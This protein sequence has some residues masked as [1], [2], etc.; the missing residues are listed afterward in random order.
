MHSC[1]ISHNRC[2]GPRGS[3]PSAPRGGARK[4]VGRACGGRR[5]VQRRPHPGIDSGDGGMTERGAS[6]RKLRGLPGAH[7]GSLAPCVPPK[8]ALGSIPA[9]GNA[10]RR[11]SRG[12]AP[13]DR[14]HVVKGKLLF[15][16]TGRCGG[17]SPGGA[18]LP[19]QGADASLMRQR[20]PK[21][22]PF[23]CCAS[24]FAVVTGGSLHDPCPRFRV[25]RPF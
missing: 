4:T 9:Q 8:K 5:R 21:D 17:L 24:G 15:P 20:S 11:V 12:L 10:S 22:F 25:S 16:S 18:R 7:I 1:G 3:G 23:F 2:Q 14:P 13:Q 6:L 19:G